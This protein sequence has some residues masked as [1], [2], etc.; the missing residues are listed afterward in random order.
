MQRR[1]VPKDTTPTLFAFGE[2][3]CYAV[4]F[5]LRRVIFARSLCERY[6]LFVANR[7]SLKSQGFNITTNRVSNITLPKAAYH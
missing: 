4:I 1:C 6:E 7:I 3:Y 2:L 5:G